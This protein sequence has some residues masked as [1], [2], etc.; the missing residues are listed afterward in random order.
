MNTANGVKTAMDI[1]EEATIKE[2]VGKEG[3]LEEIVEQAETGLLD[4]FLDYFLEDG[5]ASEDPLCHLLEQICEK[6]AVEKENKENMDSIGK[7]GNLEEIIEQAETGHLDG[8]L[9]YFL[10]EE[11]TGAPED[12]LSHMLDQICTEDAVEKEIDENEDP[13]GNVFYGQQPYNN[14]LF[15][16]YPNQQAASTVGPIRKTEKKKKVSKPYELAAPVDASVHRDVTAPEVR[17]IL[18]SPVADAIDTKRTVGDVN[19]W[20]KLNR[21]NQTKFAEKV[22][23]KTQG[24][25]SV[26]SRNPAPWEE[27]LAP[28][29]AV[30]VRMHNWMKLSDEEKM[31][32]LSVEKVSEKNNLQ[33]K[34]KKT[35]FTFPKEQM[36]VLMGIYEVN[37]RPEKKSTMNPPKNDETNSSKSVT[38]GDGDPDDQ[39]I[40]STSS[41]PQIPSI[42]HQTTAS[43]PSTSGDSNLIS[44]TTSRNQESSSEEQDISD[45]DSNVEEDPQRLKNNGFSHQN[46]AL[47]HSTSNEWN[48]ETNIRNLGDALSEVKRLDPSIAKREFILRSPSDF[49]L[50]VGNSSTSESVLQDPSNLYSSDYDPIFHILTSVDFSSDPLDYQEVLS[51]R[52]LTEC[53]DETMSAFQSPDT[54]LH[55]PE[56]H[57]S[58]D[59]PDFVATKN[60]VEKIDNF[61]VVNPPHPIEIVE[62]YIKWKDQR[63][64]GDVNI[65]TIFEEMS[66]MNPPDEPQ[67]SKNCGSS[68]DGDPDYQL[69]PSSHTQTPSTS[70]QMTVS[71]PFTPGDSNLISDTAFRSQESSSEE[72]DISD[73]DSNVEEEQSENNGSN[74]HP[75]SI[76]HQN[77]DPTPSTSNEWNQEANT[78]NLRDALSEMKKLHPSIEQDILQTETVYNPLNPNLTSSTGRAL[79]SPDTSVPQD[80]ER[81]MGALQSPD[82]TVQHP[83][84]LICDNAE[85]TK[86]AVERIDNYNVP[87]PLHPKEIVK[88]Y[89]NWRQ[90]RRPGNAN[91]KKIFGMDGRTISAYLVTPQPWDKCGKEKILY[92]RMHNWLQLSAEEKEKVLALDLN[93]Y[94]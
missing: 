46:P 26:I 79:Q 77:L 56:T 75:P 36:E 87:N 41:H 61:D 38:S 6:D 16:H 21:V 76:Y 35:R 24:H 11:S 34:K 23:E 9:D 18:D 72:Q 58:D 51:R 32:I 68:G 15:G 45:M 37:D 29:R 13:F 48:Q 42:S 39:S 54:S 64:P 63:C 62:K 17:H 88:K 33:E 57:F 14:V 78:W 66:I 93:A 44:E 27:L 10:D 65:K 55:H 67:E 81:A 73:M 92:L 12:P 47:A 71:V 94:R 86:N 74:D 1:E 28:G 30:F 5:S 83:K 3:S 31:K 59:D 2:L 7:D 19:N 70:D 4:G 50:P 52:S 91:I 8:F 49:Q 69:T 80:D 89:K 60:A 22:L 25:Y 40:L 53:D 20:L 43:V 85:A 90:E 82:N 84:S